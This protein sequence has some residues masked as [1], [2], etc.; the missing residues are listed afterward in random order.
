MYK[1]SLPTHRDW[2]VSCERLLNYGR[3]SSVLYS[4]LFITGTSNNIQAKWFQFCVIPFILTFT[5]EISLQGFELSST[6]SK[7]QITGV[8]VIEYTVVT[9]HIKVNTIHNNTCCQA[10]NYCM[11]VFKN[12]KT[13]DSITRRCNIQAMWFQFC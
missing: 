13:I 5:V 9:I 2:Y 10:T 12:H 11:I 1:I 4:R 6:Y 3:S 8:L 7:I